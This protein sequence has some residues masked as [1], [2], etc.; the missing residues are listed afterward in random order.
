MPDSHPWSKAD[1]LIFLVLVVLWALI[2]LP[3]IR[4][5]PSWYGDEGIVLEE[6]ITLAN[7][8]PRY[9]PIELNFISPNPHP[10]LYLS[11]VAV[12]MKLFGHDIIYGRILQVAV[13]L[14]TAGLAFWVGSLLID[15]RFGFLC[16]ALLLTYPEA[17]LHYRWVRGHPLQGLLSLACVG[18]LVRYIQHSRRADVLLAAFMATLALGVHYLSFPL[19]GIVAITALL[20]NRKDFSLAMMIAFAFPVLFFGWLCFFEDGGWRN[21]L[22]QFGCAFNQGI[23]SVNPNPVEELWRV[24]RTTFEFIFLTPT[25]D[26]KGHVGVDLWITGGFIGLCAFPN[27]ILRGWLVFFAISMMLGVFI[28]RD[29]PLLFIYRTFAFLPLFAIGLAG[30]LNQIGAW[31]SKIYPLRK[32]ILKILPSIL[33][34]VSCAPISI[35]G[36]IGQMRSKIDRWT[37]QSVTDAERVM[38]YVNNSTGPNDFVVMP[39]QLF[40]LYRWERKAQLI[41]CAKFDFGIEE[42]STIGVSESRY[43]FNP[44]IKNAKYL[45]LAAGSKVDGQPI[46]IDAV[47]WFGYEG[48]KKVIQKVQDEQWPIVFRSGEYCVLANP[49]F[50]KN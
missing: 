41:H 28:S 45:V 31:M 30:A 43:W 36:S 9:G 3:N 33:V 35:A 20:K 10:P 29:N 2:Y 12:P 47:F 44:S 13:G 14:L 27:K 50:N 22:G 4:T 24:Y 5:N 39:D 18:F 37:V 15:R 48:P 23:K 17:A 34:L 46:G 7:G 11:I 38:D 6:A 21:V 42:N 16:A 1:R 19:I 26:Y 40:W 49:M 8:A 25:F 32:E